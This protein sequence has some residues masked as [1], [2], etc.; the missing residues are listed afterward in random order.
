MRR[1]W[2]CHPAAAARVA[3]LMWASGPAWAGNGANFVLYN[4]Y[5]EE[6]GETEV[7]LYSDF[8]NVGG[9]EPDY[10]A[11]LLEIEHGVT[12]FW[13]AALY[14]EGTKI[15]GEHYDFGGFRVENRVRLFDYGTFLN[16]VLYVE[17]EHLKPASR[18]I[19][20]VTGRTDGEEEAG[21]EEETEHELETKLILGHDVSDRFNVAVNWINETNLDSGVWSFGYA[22]GLNY[23]LFQSAARE[24]EATREPGGAADWDIEKVTFG[25]ELYGG[26]GDDTRGLT[27]DPDQTQQYLGVNLQTKFENHLQA[28]IGGAFGL[29]RDS[30]DAI[31]RLYAGYE[32]E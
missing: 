24:D 9:V 3:A 30:Q 12:D 4:H 23:A 16:P 6:K 1:V 28:G 27:L 13:T 32:F 25:A 11:Q 26:L 2:G 14:L 22:L 15:E 21:A 7:R 29:T 19:R 31:L 10:S 5:T 8:A 18:Y 20:S 17:Y